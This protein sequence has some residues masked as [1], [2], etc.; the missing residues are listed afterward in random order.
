MRILDLDPL[1]AA[2]LLERLLPGRPLSALEDDVATGIA[3]DMMSALWQ[4]LPVGHSFETVENLAAGLNRLR[5]VSA[6]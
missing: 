2:L 3:A 6:V 5:S 4:P 1:A